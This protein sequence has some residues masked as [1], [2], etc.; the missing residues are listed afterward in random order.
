MII[1]LLTA[2]NDGASGEL[3]FSELSRHVTL[4]ESE[5]DDST[6]TTTTAATD[7]RPTSHTFVVERRRGR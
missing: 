4:Y 3:E 7:E 1:L 2:A 5:G 6:T